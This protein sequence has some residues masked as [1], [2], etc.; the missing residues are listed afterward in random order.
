M[1]DSKVSDEIL[2][3]IVTQKDVAD[4]KFLAH[5]MLTALCESSLSDE[6]EYYKVAVQEDLGLDVQTMDRLFSLSAIARLLEPEIP[7]PR[8]YRGK[9]VPKKDN[10]SKPNWN[11]MLDMILGRDVVTESKSEQTDPVSFEVKTEPVIDQ[12]PISDVEQPD[13][14]QSEDAIRQLEEPEKNKHP[15]AKALRKLM[16]DQNVQIDGMR[17]DTDKYEK[18]LILM[19]NTKPHK[20]FLK[21]VGGKW[22]AR[23]GVWQL[24]KDHL[25]SLVA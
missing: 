8:Y 7:K 22:S 19:G 10:E 24:S 20:D 5:K 12:V 4:D 2:S 15:A 9:V 18:S 21:S 16:R 13:T 17:I 14:F 3:G 1:Q 11:Q 23:S 6:M 25:V